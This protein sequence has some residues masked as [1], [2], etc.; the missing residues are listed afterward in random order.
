MKVYRLFVVWNHR[1]TVAILP[2]ILF[3]IDLGKPSL[4][5]LSWFVQEK[6]HCTV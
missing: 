4:C 6:L 3:L 5:F 2:A 1:R